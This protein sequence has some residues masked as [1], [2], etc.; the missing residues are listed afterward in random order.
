[1]VIQPLPKN[2]QREE[3]NVPSLKKKGAQ[4]A[5]NVFFIEL[6]LFFKLH[7]GDIEIFLSMSPY[8]HMPGC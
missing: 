6:P 7:Y 5:R 2:V 8:F 3:E 1:M 4:L